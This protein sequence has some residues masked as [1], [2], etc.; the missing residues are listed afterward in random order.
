MRFKLTG[1]AFSEEDKYLEEGTIVGDGSPHKWTRPPNH[2]MEGLDEESQAAIEALPG[3][4]DPLDGLPMTIGPEFDVSMLGPQDKA[5][6][7]AMLT[8]S[9][10]TEVATDKALQGPRSEPG[11]TAA[12]GQR[13]TNVRS[14]ARPLT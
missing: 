12:P 11:L 6:L 7:L 10:G 1:P 9:V 13:V 8:G 2:D 14:G 4:G 3:S 5:R